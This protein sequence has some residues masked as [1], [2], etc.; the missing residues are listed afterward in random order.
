[1][2]RGF[3]EGDVASFEIELGFGGSSEDFG[4]TVIELTFPWQ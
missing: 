1:L 4:A 2:P 3:G